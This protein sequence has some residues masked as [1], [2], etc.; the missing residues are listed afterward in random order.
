MEEN[1]DIYK[2]TLLEDRIAGVNKTDEKIP[3]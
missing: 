2:Y 3:S 1:K